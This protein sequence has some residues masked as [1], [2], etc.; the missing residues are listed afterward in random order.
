MTKTGDGGAAAQVAQLTPRGAPCYFSRPSG[1]AAVDCLQ[2]G[3]LEGE[4]LPDGQ[5]RRLPPALRWSPGL[6]NRRRIRPGAVLPVFRCGDAVRTTRGPDLRRRES[7]RRE[8]ARHDAPLRAG[9]AQRLAPGGSHA[10]HPATAAS[11]PESRSPISSP[12]ANPKPWN[13]GQELVRAARRRGKRY[14]VCQLPCR[15]RAT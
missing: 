13:E 15:S 8:A 6:Y 4:P 5:H 2:G 12:S 10:V 11:P 9:H 14:C 1:R 7:C 3:R